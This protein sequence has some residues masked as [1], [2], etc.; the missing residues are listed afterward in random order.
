VVL[1]SHHAPVLMMGDRKAA[2]LLRQNGVDGL[3]VVDLPAGE[4]SLLRAVGDAGLA[5]VPFASPSGSG[6]V[7]AVLRERADRPDAPRAYVHLLTGS[8]G[9]MRGA[10]ESDPPDA[11][12]PSTRAIGLISARVQAAAM[13]ARAEMPVVIGSVLA[14]GIDSGPS[15][16]KA[17]GPP[18]EG[19]DGVI[20]DGAIT[21][22][23]EDSTSAQERID[24]IRAL[25]MGLREGL[26]D[27]P[28]RPSYY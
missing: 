26:D 8:A 22:I 1:S 12:P 18:G 17:A 11:A 15:A 27:A 2:R 28:N 3:L 5:M 9:L 19:A 4:R 21:L 24:R 14:A 23:I 20:V 7:D 13:R 16:R 10:R 6:G 25:I